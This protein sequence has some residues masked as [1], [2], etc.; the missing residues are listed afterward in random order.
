[1]SRIRIF[2]AT[3]IHGSTL[4]FKKF[5]NSAKFYKA[6]IIIMG[7]DITGK[8]IIPIIKKNNYYEY[9]YLGTNYKFTDNDELNKHIKRI[10][11]GG[12]YT[13]IL[14]EDEWIE[15]QNNKDKLNNIFEKVIGETLSEWINYAD[16][17]L[18]K[19]N[20]KCFIQPGNDDDYIVDKILEEAETIINPNEKVVEVGENLQ[21]VSLGYSNITPWRCPRDITE[22]E[23]NKKIETLMKNVNEGA[24][25]IFNIH[26]PPYGTGIDEAPE[27]DENMRPKMGPGGVIITKPVGSISVREAILKHQPILGL[28][29]HIHEA[30]GFAKLGRTL[31]LNPG[32][33]YQEGILRG[34]L[35]QLKDNRIRDY[36]FTSG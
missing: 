15:A 31:C 13:A 26:V 14:D 32:S 6:D 30:R 35:I 11:E 29:G 18:R 25:I 24:D 10:R 22:E 2:F 21:M 34:V 17:K 9:T 5:I 1:M 12:Y 19:S 28:H 20:V 3:D 33:E 36:L 7:G 16:N 27:L 8:F 23:L 4:C